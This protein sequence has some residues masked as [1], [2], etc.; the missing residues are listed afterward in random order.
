ME[1]WK[2]ITGFEGL[3]QVSD[4][5]N[6]RSMDYKGH[7]YTHNLKQRQDKDGYMVINMSKDKT[8]YT[9][10]VHRLVAQMFIENP[11]HKSQVNHIDETTWNNAVTNLEWS[12]PMENSNHGSKNKAI[13]QYTKAG[14]IVKEWKSAADISVHFYGVRSKGGNVTNCCKGK[15]K[16]FKGYIWRYTNE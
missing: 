3:Y 15:I 14:D 8:P 6:V 11:L 9:F 10:K 1:E 4:L 16:S 2:D 13:T 12:T 5:G 7:G